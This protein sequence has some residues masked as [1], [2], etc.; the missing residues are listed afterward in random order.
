MQQASWRCWGWCAWCTAPTTTTRRR[1]LAM[2]WRCSR[3]R[4]RASRSLQAGSRSTTR[5]HVSARA[6]RCCRCCIMLRCAALPRP[7]PRTVAMCDGRARFLKPSLLLSFPS[8]L[9]LPSFIPLFLP[10]P[11]LPL[12]LPHS[13]LPSFPP[14]LTPAD[15]VKEIFVDAGAPRE[16]IRRH[17]Y[18]IRFI[19]LPMAFND[20]VP[21]PP[22][23]VTPGRH[24]VHAAV[25]IR[26]RCCRR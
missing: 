6:C 1:R 23:P 12:S 14:S 11:L 16:L 9:T 8:S 19:P 15:Y 22:R 18:S 25:R 3:W 2:R 26:R 13:L 20:Q 7:L 5:M 21:R 10:P 24:S 4:A 17:H